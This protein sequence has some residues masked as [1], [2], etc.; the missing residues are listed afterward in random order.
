M[1]DL[2]KAAALC[3]P[4]IISKSKHQDYDRTCELSR[5]YRAL[6][7]GEDLDYLMRQF[8]RRESDAEFEQRKRI[9]KHITPSIVETLMNP[10]RKLQGVKPV[11]DK[12]DF[13]KDNDTKAQELRNILADFNGGRDVDYYL[14]SLVEP[15]DADPNAFVLLTFD[16]F[17][18]R[19]EKPTTYPVLIGC[20][21][22]YDFQY[23]NNELQYLWIHRC[24]QYPISTDP[25]GKVTMTAG[26]K[27]V[28]YVDDFHIVF[29]QVKEDSVVGNVEGRYLDQFGQPIEILTN[30]S[31][32][33]GADALYYFRVNKTTLYQVTF[34]DQNSGQVPAF[35][36]GCKTDQYTN[37]RTCVNRWH[38]ALPYLEKSL[39][40]V[41]ELDLT[42]ALHAFPQKLQYVGKCHAR[43]C[44][45]GWIGPNQEKECESCKGTG[46]QTITSA[47]D[48]MQ[49]PLP[50]R[51]EDLRDLSMMTHYVQLPVDLIQQMRDIVKDT[52][53]DAIKAVFSSDVFARPAVAR[54]ATEANIDMQS[55]YDAEQPHAMWWGFVRCIIVK[56]VAAYNDMD[57]D[58]RVV[59]RFPRNFKFDTL[60][61]LIARLKNLSVASPSARSMVNMDVL[62]QLYIDDPDALKKAQTQERFNPFPG[63][64]DATIMS[65]IVSNAA[66]ERSAFIWVEMAS[67]FNEAEAQ[68]EGKEVEFYDLDETKQRKVIDEI[69]TRML[70]EK[71][72]AKEAVPFGATLGAVDDQGQGGSTADPNATDP[73]A[74][75]QQMGAA[76]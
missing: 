25:S 2:P 26:E 33:F 69:V 12:I 71:N 40:Q 23:F 65:I 61:D 41:S 45:A 36:I 44:N 1:I 68:F 58:L 3:V 51:G 53:T 66:T 46:L 8:N 22:V 29:S 55:V 60:D 20:E 37:N 59:F 35:R 32:A 34:Y 54:T 24:I 11:V 6:M 52:R 63:L 70:E 4:R 72:A 50:A 9:T 15:S 47:Q 16:N 48:H 43:N 75:P 21:D 17:D 28:L 67:I 18:Q 76:A 74:D 42:T 5:K 7:T 10:A 19:Y 27:F 39:K 64:E 31:V 49:F 56:V 30:D 13:G 57:K 38:S 73:S 14:G 62:A